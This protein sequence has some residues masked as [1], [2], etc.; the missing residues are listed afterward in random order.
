MHGRVVRRVPWDEWWRERRTWCERYVDRKFPTFTY[1]DAEDVV[2]SVAERYVNA[3]VDSIVEYEGGW[4]MPE[5]DGRTLGDIRT[6]L[7]RRAIDLWQAQRTR[8]E[9]E[10]WLFDADG[11]SPPSAVAH[12]ADPVS[13]AVI[14]A[15]ALVALCMRLKLDLA[16][17]DGRTQIALQYV[18]DVYGRGRLDSAA[19]LR[20]PVIL[21][22]QHSNPVEHEYSALIDEIALALDPAYRCLNGRSE[23]EFRAAFR[24]GPR[25]R[26]SALMAPWKA[27]ITSALAVHLGHAAGPDD[28]NA[29][30]RESTGDDPVD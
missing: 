7:T 5:R 17:A 10:T 13:D 2:A 30:G 22:N 4:V 24:K 16:Q 25:P 14:R 19:R 1:A 18:V 6:H 9:T 11:A 3:R 21:R 29:S 20:P 15:G 28:F 12:K 26:V 27:S 8:A 23:A